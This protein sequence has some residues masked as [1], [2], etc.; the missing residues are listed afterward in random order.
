MAI[1][2]IKSSESNEQSLPETSAVM[3]KQTPRIQTEEGWKRSQLKKH[4]AV[5]KTIKSK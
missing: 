3:K 5:K 2:K 4:M 1:E